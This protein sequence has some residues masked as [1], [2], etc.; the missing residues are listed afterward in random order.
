[1]LIAMPVDREVPSAMIH[2]PCD[3]NA[4]LLLRA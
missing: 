1:M 2:N 4:A 3:R